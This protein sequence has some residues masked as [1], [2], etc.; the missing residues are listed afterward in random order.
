MT[1]AIRAPIRNLFLAIACLLA[2]IAPASAKV[3]VTFWSQDFSGNFP[4]AFFTLRGTVEATGEAV[5]VSYGFTP[6][7]MTPAILMGSV[8][9]RIDLTTDK[10]IADSNAH[11]SSVVSDAQFASLRSLVVEWGEQGDHRYNLNRRNCVHFVA[12]A[13]RRAGLRVEEPKKLMKKPRSFTQS[14]AALNV[15]RV[16]VIERP[17]REYLATLPPL[18]PTGVAAA[19]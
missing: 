4:H 5:N 18:A 7:A 9:G 13:M 16:A 10:Y 3:T 15:G 1:T 12:E 6:K 14:V 11:F 17:A 19:R 2:T 8:P